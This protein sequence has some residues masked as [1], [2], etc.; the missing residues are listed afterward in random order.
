MIAV[1]YV[2]TQGI[3]AG[4]QVQFGPGNAYELPGYLVYALEYQFSVLIPR[5]RKCSATLNVQ[6]RLSVV[7]S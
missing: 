3:C 4:S 2:D 5:K 1:C 7:R 6:E